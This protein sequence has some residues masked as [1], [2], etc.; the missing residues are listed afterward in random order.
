MRLLLVTSIRDALLAISE[1]FAPLEPEDVPLE[2]AGNRYTADEVIAREDIPAFTRSTVDGYALRAFETFGA[3]ESLPAV[4]KLVGEVQMGKPAPHISPGECC[5]VPTGGMLPTQADAVVMIEQTEIT[6]DQVLVLR[7]VAPGENRILQGEDLRRG[8]VVFSR[9]RKLRGP[10]LGLLASLGLTS[11]KVIRR[12]LVCLFS[13]GDEIVPVETPVLAPGQVR[14][15]NRFGLAHLAVTQMGAVVIDG[16]I[17]PDSRE[18]FQNRVSS[19]LQEADMVVVSGGSSVG[20][21]DF[22]TQ[23]LRDLAGGELLLE[24]LAVQPGK[25][26]LL[27]NCHGKPVLGL[28]GHP[29]SALNIFALIGGAILRRLSGAIGEEWRPSIRAVLAKDISSRP[30]RTDLVRVALTKAAD[31]PI[32]TPVLGRSGLLRTLA[33]ADG[34]IWVPEERD[35]LPAGETVEVYLGI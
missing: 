20:N 23:T 16:G 6:A 13:T 19:A 5:Y 10:E 24:G 3:T 35:G 9:G 29:I 21:R 4:Q 8:Q 17:L 25:P 15:A 18:V 1:S 2:V 26:T 27:A 33:E 30:G 34:L 14:D 28:P 32:A 11:V 22:T 12:P 7:P 31:L